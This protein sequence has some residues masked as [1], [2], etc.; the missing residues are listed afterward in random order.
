[1][2]N[3]MI[4]PKKIEGNYHFTKEMARAYMDNADFTHPFII[5]GPIGVGKKTLVSEIIDEYSSFNIETIEVFPSLC[6]DSAIVDGE[7]SYFNKC[8]TAALNA[9]RVNSKNPHFVILNTG[10]FEFPLDSIIGEG[11]AVNI[12]R[13]DREEWIKWAESSDETGYCSKIDS[14]I[15]DFVKESDEAIFHPNIFI[16][17]NEKYILRSNLSPEIKELILRTR[18]NYELGQDCI[19]ALRKL[20]SSQNPIVV[21]HPWSPRTI[22]NISW[23]FRE[24][25]IKLFHYDYIDSAGNR[26]KGTLDNQD[27]EKDLNHCYDYDS[28]VILSTFGKCPI[29]DKEADKWYSKIIDARENYKYKTT[30]ITDELFIGALSHVTPQAWEDWCKSCLPVESFKSLLKKDIDKI[31]VTKDI[32]VPLLINDAKFQC[33]DFLCQRIKN[34]YGA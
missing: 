2:Q 14:F 30:K 25:L 5:A 24:S 11:Y 22:H 8:I 1:M 15:I 17:A 32:L 21:W 16:H 12:L 19:D 34:Y 18:T 23:H 3:I 7:A 33:G 28:L 13:F 26:I 31:D 20:A 10:F 4:Q 9:I 6:L 29:D 27:E